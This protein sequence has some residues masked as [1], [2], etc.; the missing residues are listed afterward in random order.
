MAESYLLSIR[1]I[2]VF[3]H[4]GWYAEERVLGQYY[5]IDVVMEL[6]LKHGDMSE[7]ESTVNYEGVVQRIRELFVPEARLI[8]ELAQRIYFALSVF[9]SAVENIGVRVTKIHPPMN[10]VGQTSVSIDP[11]SLI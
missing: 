9:H 5:R 8:E 1:D 10:E 3:G 4:H 7:I 11:K 6:P 2:Q